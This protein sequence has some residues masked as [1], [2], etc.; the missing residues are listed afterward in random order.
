LEGCTHERRDFSQNLQRTTQSA[1]NRTITSEMIFDAL[2]CTA[3]RAANT[4]HRVRGTWH[5]LSIVATGGPHSVSAVRRLRRPSQR[6]LCNFL[7]FHQHALKASPSASF[8]DLDGSSAFLKADEADFSADDH[9]SV[10]PDA[11][12]R[13]HLARRGCLGR[14]SWRRHPLTRRPTASCAGSRHSQARRFQRPSRLLT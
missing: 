7:H 1:F 12:F 11:L 4:P 6:A 9:C 13:S 5:G 8:C 2:V 10:L 14:I 3:A